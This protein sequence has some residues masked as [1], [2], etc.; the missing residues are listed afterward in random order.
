MIGSCTECVKI[1][2]ESR[3]TRNIC[4]D[5][6]LTV[7]SSLLNPVRYVQLWPSC[8]WNSIIV[9]CRRHVPP[10]VCLTMAGCLF[11]SPAKPPPHTTGTSIYS[12]TLACI[13]TLQWATGQNDDT[14]NIRTLLTSWTACFP[15]KHNKGVGF[16]LFLYSTQMFHNISKRQL[17]Q[18]R[19]ASLSLHS[20]LKKPSHLK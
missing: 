8:W 5:V 6:E 1:A 15:L 16:L 10:A 3:Q 4:N 19:K 14:A 17:R 9:N 7:L 20:R 18:R 2:L 12:F 13:A 11:I